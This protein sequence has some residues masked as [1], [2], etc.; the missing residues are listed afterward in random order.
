MEVYKQFTAPPDGTM[1]DTAGRRVWPSAAPLL[2]TILGEQHRNQTVLEL[3]TGC[4]LIGMALAASRRFQ[5]VVMT[6]Y[7]LERNIA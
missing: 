7:W 5:K 2:K 6:D 1:V 3:G 4:G